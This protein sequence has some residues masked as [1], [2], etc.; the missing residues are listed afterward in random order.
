MSNT[1]QPEQ[2]NSFALAG[3]SAGEHDT[4]LSPLAPAG[5]DSETLELP[6]AALLALRKSGGLRFSSRTLVVYRDGR[7]WSD[8]EGARLRRIGADD[9]AR[10]RHLALRARLARHGSPG[11]GQPPD[12]YAYE[13]AVRVGRRVRRAEL[14]DGHIP[15][16]VAALLR[17]LRQR[18]P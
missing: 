9:L 4:S 2:K 8:A 7:V 13:I 14:L 12:G 11:A 16:E 6:R 10:L 5:D 1:D 15:A 17:A 3:L 18:K